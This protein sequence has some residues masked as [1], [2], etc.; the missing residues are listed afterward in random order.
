MA[1][2]FGYSLSHTR[3]CEHLKCLMLV[4]LTTFVAQCV[5]SL[6]QGPLNS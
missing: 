2:A 5:D 6:C 4:E 1:T 3:A